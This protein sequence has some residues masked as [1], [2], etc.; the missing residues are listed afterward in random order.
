MHRSEVGG[1][2]GVNPF[3]EKPGH[4]S[5][6]K[7]DLIFFW[8][9]NINKFQPN[10]VHTFLMGLFFI[11][12]RIVVRRSKVKATCPFLHVLVSD[13]HHFWFL[14]KNM[15]KRPFSMGLGIYTFHWVKWLFYYIWQILPFLYQ[16]AFLCKNIGSSTKASISYGNLY[17]LYY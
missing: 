9:M 2:Y 4:N 5:Q 14:W 6:F 3:T 15:W 1:C 7:G 11:P 17:T 16:F 13:C 8:K 10:L 12:V